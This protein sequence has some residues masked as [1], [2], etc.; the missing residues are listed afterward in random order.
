MSNFNS[1]SLIIP[2]RERAET[3]FWTIQSALLNEYEHLEIII[4]DNF[5]SD[6]TQEVVNS[7]KDKR[8]K[9]FR[10]SERLSMS[11]NFEFA[12]SRATNDY[13]ISIGDDDAVLPSTFNYLNDLITNTKVEAVACSNVSYNWDN[14]LDVSSRNKLSWSFKRGFEIRHTKEWLEDFFTFRPGYTHDLPCIYCGVVSR[15]VINK[16][17]GEGLFFR[18]VTPDA[19]SSFAI[20]H[21]IDEY[22]YSF[23]PFV[24]HGASGKSNGASGFLGKDES[25]AKKFIIENTILTN[26]GIVICPSFRVHAMEAYLQFRDNYPSITKDNFINWKKFLCAVK[27]EIK[28]HNSSQ[29]NDAIEKM[30]LLYSVPVSEIKPIIKFPLLK[31]VKFIISKLTNLRNK[32]FI[33]DATVF[34]V[35]N[36]RDAALLLNFLITNERVKVSNSLDMVFNKFRK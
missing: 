11:S 6:N 1:F 15:N 26:D 12:L 25:E 13:I 20:S 27:S 33:K 2:T 35:Y 30:A 16:I 18:S 17:K 4:S 5:S 19:Y 29:F 8:I 10:T 36:V 32:Y 3:L 34:G 21:F 31:K 14:F 23:T 28:K 22:I 24:I 7:F 9:Y